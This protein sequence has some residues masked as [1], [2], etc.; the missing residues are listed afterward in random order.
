MSPRSACIYF[1][2]SAISPHSLVPLVDSSH[3]SLLW[4]DRLS[5]LTASSTALSGVGGLMGV[6]DSGLNLPSEKGSK[7]SLSKPVAAVP[8]RLLRPKSWGS[9]TSPFHTH[10]QSVSK[11][12]WPCFQNTSWAGSFSY[13]RPGNPGQSPTSPEHALLS[14]GCPCSHPCPPASLSCP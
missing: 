9:L 1:Y 12:C 2:Y 14:P 5:H 6:S 3:L 8:V 7:T 13:P 10:F 4:R 11:T